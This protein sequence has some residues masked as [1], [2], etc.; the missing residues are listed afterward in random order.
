MSK[1]LNLVRKKRNNVAWH[2]LLWGPLHVPRCSFIAWLCFLNRL[3]PQIKTAETGKEYRHNLLSISTSSRRQGSLILLLQFHQENMAVYFK[4]KWNLQAGDR[5]EELDCAISFLQKKCI[6]SV[7]LRILRCSCVYQIW[8]ERN[9][10]AH[11]FDGTVASVIVHRISS[12]DKLRLYKTK[13]YR[14]LS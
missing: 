3:F 5:Q 10:R 11:G 14:K 1:C 4:E 6:L 13:I 12:F 8:K 7:L 2:K 9:M